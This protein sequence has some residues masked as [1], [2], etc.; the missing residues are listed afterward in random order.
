[1][2]IMTP[3]PDKALI[4]ILGYHTHDLAKLVKRIAQ[5]S[6]CMTEIQAELARRRETAR[7]DTIVTFYHFVS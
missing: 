1:M 2:D 4:E 7:I 6:A 5:I 3:V